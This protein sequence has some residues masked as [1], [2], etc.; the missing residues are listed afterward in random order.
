M[1]RDFGD[2]DEQY[3]ADLI[4][5]FAEHPEWRFS[6]DTDEAVERVIEAA[7]EGRSVEHWFNHVETEGNLRVEIPTQRETSG[8]AYGELSQSLYPWPEPSTEEPF[9]N[10]IV[11]AYTSIAERANA[12]YVTADSTPF[13]VLTVDVPADYD[14]EILESAITSISDA[15]REVQNLH[16]DLTGVLESYS[17][18]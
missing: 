12:D 11:E 14:P 8:V 15:S 3:F 16:D 18:E 10:Q 2:L 1:S 9:L 17:N 13:T 5:Q 7:E 6:G 4:N